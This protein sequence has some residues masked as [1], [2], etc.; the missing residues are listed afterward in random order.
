MVLLLFFKQ[1]MMDKTDP[2]SYN[3]SGK[4]IVG[5]NLS[6][7]KLHVFRYVWYMFSPFKPKPKISNLKIYFRS[8]MY[9]IAIWVQAATPWLCF[10]ASQSVHRS[11]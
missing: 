1:Y 7:K 8:G 9:C 10:V 4:K 3:K 2:G 5:E 6:S 11:D